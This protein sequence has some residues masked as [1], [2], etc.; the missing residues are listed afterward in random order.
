MDVVLW[1]S[2]S[3]TV[4]IATP[5]A[6]EAG[7]GV[8]QSVEADLGETGLLAEIPESPAHELRAESRAVHPG[9]CE[10]VLDP[11]SPP[12]GTVGQLSGPVIEEY[13]QGRRIDAHDHLHP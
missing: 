1:P 12:G 13:L 4:F 6:S 8:P 3:L 2:L 7:A 5:A 10:S 9:E 11:G